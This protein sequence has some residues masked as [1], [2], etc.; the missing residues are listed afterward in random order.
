MRHTLTACF[1]AYALGSAYA[2]P[3]AAVPADPHNDRWQTCY[4]HGSCSKHQQPYSC[5]QH[6]DFPGCPAEMT[7]CDADCCSYWTG[8]QNPVGYGHGCSPS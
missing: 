5:L 8:F 3:I 6:P 4:W 7:G 2:G 1:L